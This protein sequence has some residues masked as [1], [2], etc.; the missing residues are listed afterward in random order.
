MPRITRR[1]KTAGTVQ[2]Q[3]EVAANAI[4]ILDT[5]VDNDFD[6]IYKLTNGNLDDDNISGSPK[7]IAKSKLNLDGAIVP[8]DLAP[9]FILPSNA[10]VS[11]HSI[12][13]TQ[14]WAPAAANS[15]VVTTT[16]PGPFV[17]SVGNISLFASV[18]TG[19]PVTAKRDDSFPF[20]TTETVYNEL[21]WT[22]RGG[23]IF[24][25]ATLQGDVTPVDADIGAGGTVHM[26]IWELGNPGAADGNVLYTRTQNIIVTPGHV[27]APPF[28][29]AGR[30]QVTIVIPFTLGLRTPGTYRLK[31][32]LWVPT[33]SVGD[34]EHRYSMLAAVELA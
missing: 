34:L 23:P 28:A 16:N 9:G 26:Q 27:V 2:F 12:G 19:T 24:A 6:D 10:N 11:P 33:G 31:M 14:L 7:R 3:T 4:A 32:S 29:F 1:P 13:P 20:P 30:S 17:T 25:I 8:G 22:T 18:Q 15:G 21:S 5:E